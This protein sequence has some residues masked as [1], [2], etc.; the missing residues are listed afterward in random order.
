[1]DENM[2]DLG[3]DVAT[4]L[5]E[6]PDPVITLTGADSYTVQ[7]T[8]DHP[9]LALSVYGKSVQYGTPT[10]DAPIDIVSVG[11]DGAVIITV[12]NGSNIALSAEITSGLPFCSV[13]NVR[14]ELVYNAD[15]TGNRRRYLIS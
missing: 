9:L 1:M 15:G 13:G 11:D 5:A 7:D 4:I 8:A 12:G 14:D 6:L 10:P 3:L 2:F